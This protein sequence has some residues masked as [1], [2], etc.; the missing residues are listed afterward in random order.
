MSN[1]LKWHC[2]MKK[3]KG[4]TCISEIVKVKGQA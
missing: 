3:L 4:Q 2:L 1:D